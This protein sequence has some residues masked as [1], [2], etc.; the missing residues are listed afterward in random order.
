MATKVRGRST[1][2]EHTGNLRLSR[3]GN[4]M[5]NIFWLRMLYHQRLFGADGQVLHGYGRSAHQPYEKWGG[6]Q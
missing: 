4:S 1:R 6:S 2:S 5:N 3:I